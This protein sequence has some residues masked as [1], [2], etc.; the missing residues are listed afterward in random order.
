L[1]RLLAAPPPT[2]VHIASVIGAAAGHMIV[3]AQV[4]LR[5]AAGPPPQVQRRLLAG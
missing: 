2:D 1:Q 3:D 5:L 4:Q